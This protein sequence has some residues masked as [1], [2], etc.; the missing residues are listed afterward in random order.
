MF[1]APTI[2]K[3]VHTYKNVE[4]PRKFLLSKKKISQKKLIEVSS[5]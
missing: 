3:G 4:K 1:K 2:N 5:P